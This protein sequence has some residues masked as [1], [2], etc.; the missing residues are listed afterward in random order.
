VHRVRAIGTVEGQSPNQ[1]LR[2]DA[3][4]SVASEYGSTVVMTGL[5]NFSFFAVGAAIASSSAKRARPQGAGP[6]GEVRTKLIIMI[7]IGPSLNVLGARGLLL[8]AREL[9]GRGVGHGWGPF[10]NPNSARMRRL[11]P[12]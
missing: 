3:F 9:L 11:V 2:D 1:I 5:I 6:V 10:P 7:N 4:S 12:W 8:S